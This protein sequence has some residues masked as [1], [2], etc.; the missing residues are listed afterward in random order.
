[1]KT[2]KITFFDNDFGGAAKGA[3]EALSY[4]IDLDETP[5]DF[6]LKEFKLLIHLL[7]N[8]N[9]RTGESGYS[10]VN[11]SYWDSCTVKILDYI[12]KEW[13][14][15]ESVVCNTETGEVTLL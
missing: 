12:P 5:E 11:K 1:M 2:I 14:N 10:E 8:I 15:S 6:I 3:M 4:V 13:N 9:Y 7:A